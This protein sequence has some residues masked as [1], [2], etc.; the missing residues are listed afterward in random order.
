MSFIDS[1]GFSRNGPVFVS[2]PL[3]A[4]EFCKK[5][6]LTAHGRLQI[7]DDTRFLHRFGAMQP[8]DLKHGLEPRVLRFFA[9]VSDSLNR[10]STKLDD[11]YPILELI[12][13]QY[14]PAWLLLAHLIEE[15]GAD[16]TGERTLEVLNRYLETGPANDEQRKTWELTARMYRRRGDWL[17]YIDS[18]VRIA[19]LPDADLITVSGAA[20]TLNSVK[21]ELDPS[22]K[23]DFVRRLITAMD[24]KIIDGD[25]T[26]CSRLAWLF[27]QDGNERRARELVRVGLRLDPENEFCLNLVRKLDST[28]SAK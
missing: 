11:E 1:Y 26:D 25:A 5:K 4:S 19:E 23:R 16:H 8:V 3:A 21:T 7:E 12:A 22:Q 18:S 20:N 27:L 14:P 13:R 28:S 9:A 17:G 24:P 6:L 2:A 15:A 10:K